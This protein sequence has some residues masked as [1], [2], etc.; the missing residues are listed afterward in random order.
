M[1]DKSKPIT[2]YKCKLF[3]LI[4]LMH[5]VGREHVLT[6]LQ[7]F[8]CISTG[9]SLCYLNASK[10]KHL[11]YSKGSSTLKNPSGLRL[12]E[13]FFFFISLFLATTAAATATANPHN[14]IPVGTAH[15]VAQACAF[16]PACH[17]ASST[18][19]HTPCCQ[20]PK[21]SWPGQDVQ[22]PQPG[23]D[24]LTRLLL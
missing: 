9:K 13:V 19:T 5:L 14:S 18:A 11:S 7:V 16:H 12:N 6:N 10:R 21:L 24:D 4:L 23:G 3:P 20:P 2:V 8:R 17:T 22:V 15:L 1:A